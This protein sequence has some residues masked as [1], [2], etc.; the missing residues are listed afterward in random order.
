MFF[1]LTFI[2]IT[3]LTNG[4]LC[5]MFSDLTFIPVRV[6]V[7]DSRQTRAEPGVARGG[8]VVSV[9][10]TYQLLVLLEQHVCFLVLSTKVGMVLQDTRLMK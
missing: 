5:F 2:P 3:H 8:P 6:E 9:V 1:A 10:G 4:T 7:P